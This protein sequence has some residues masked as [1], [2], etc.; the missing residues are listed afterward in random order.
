MKWNAKECR[1]WRPILTTVCT[2]YLW[3]LTYSSLVAPAVLYGSHLSCIT[4]PLAHMPRCFR[5]SLK[6]EHTYNCGLSRFQTPSTALESWVQ[7][8]SL[9]IF[10]RVESF[11]MWVPALGQVRRTDQLAAAFTGW[12]QTQEGW[13]TQTNTLTFIFWNYAT[14]KTTAHA[15]MC[16]ISWHCFKSVRQTAKENSSFIATTNRVI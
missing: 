7:D 14:S 1:W 12:L 2:T 10:W 4:S 15:V 9:L 3:G 13:S 5:L 16:L 8:T 11:H 6:P